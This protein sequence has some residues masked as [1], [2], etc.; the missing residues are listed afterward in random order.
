MPAK[1]TWPC[2]ITGLLCPE[3]CLFLSLSR[4]R[5]LLATATDQRTLRMCIGRSGELAGWGVGA[6]GLVNKGIG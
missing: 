4:V 6:G 5:G 1:L 3:P 2:P